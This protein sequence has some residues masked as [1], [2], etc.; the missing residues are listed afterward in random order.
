MTTRCR[1]SWRVTCSLTCDVRQLRPREAKG[2]NMQDRTTGGGST[3][4]RSFSTSG[5]IRRAPGRE[6]LNPNLVQFSGGKVINPG[7]RSVAGSDPEG[8]SG[9]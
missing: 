2:A 1:S 3:V 4:P 8:R 9:E 6:F 7:T 5:Q